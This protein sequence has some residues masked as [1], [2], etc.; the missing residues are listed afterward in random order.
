MTPST[1]SARVPDF[2]IVGHHKSGTTALYRM[3]RRHPQIFMPA[4]KEPKFF[5]S[6][7]PARLEPPAAGTLPGTLKEYLALF[8]DARPDQRAGEAS[9][10]YLR[11]HVAAGLIAQL[12]PAARIVAILREPASFVR[13]LHLQLVQSHV[14]SEKD[15]AK[16]LAA[17][18]VVRGGQQMR[19]YSDHV[20]YV[21]QLRRYHAVFPRERVLVLIYDDF[22]AEN[23]ATVRRVLRFLDVDDTV[24]V[25][26]IEANPT[27]GVRSLRLDDT[28]RALYEGRGPLARIVKNTVKTIT[29]TR[30][31]VN[32][33]RAI[34]GRLVYGKPPPPDEDVMAQLRHRF[35]AEVLALSEYMDRDLVELWG[36]DGIA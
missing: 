11:S 31:R 22:R 2:F 6:D 9:P 14:E 33:S 8:A 28:V 25:D 20:R 32:A 1:D 35:K 16:A 23:E 4:L 36:Y 5:A 7:L 24:R 13:S 27:V 19:R 26:P 3:L 34:R 17:E 10:S 30:L 21:E 12:Q 18:D 15:L 29:P